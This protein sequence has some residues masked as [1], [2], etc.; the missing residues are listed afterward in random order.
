[1]DAIAQDVV[2][3]VAADDA[4]AH[5]AAEPVGKHRQHGVHGALPDERLEGFGV[6]LVRHSSSSEVSGNR[7]DWRRGRG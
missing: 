4:L 1:V 2:E 6:R 3:E 7:R 5:E